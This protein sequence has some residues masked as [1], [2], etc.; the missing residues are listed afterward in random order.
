MCFTLNSGYN[1][2][3]LSG[4]PKVELIVLLKYPAEQNKLQF[5]VIL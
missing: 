2:F 4:V 3:V 1:I 5:Y